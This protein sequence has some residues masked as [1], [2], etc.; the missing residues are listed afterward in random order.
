VI[1]KRLL[2]PIH[3]GRISEKNKDEIIVNMDP[4]PVDNDLGPNLDIESHSNLKPIT[5]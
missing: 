2:P 5:Y 4:V 1:S 3:S